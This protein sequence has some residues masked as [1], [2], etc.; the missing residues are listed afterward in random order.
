MEDCKYKGTYKTEFT[1]HRTGAVSVGNARHGATTYIARCLRGIARDQ[2]LEAVPISFLNPPIAQDDHPVDYE[3]LVKRANDIRKKI[4]NE[5]RDKL[6]VG[7]EVKDVMEYIKDKYN[8]N[9][10]LATDI[11]EALN[12]IK[13]LKR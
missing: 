7:W 3:I 9:E 2:L 10:I 4:L 12:I 11:E 6:T 5:G 1:V 13:R 8:I